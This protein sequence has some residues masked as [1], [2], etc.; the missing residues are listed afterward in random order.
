ME[1]NF[2]TW[3]TS[4]EL[5][6]K[7]IAEYSLEQLNA[8]PEGFSNNLIWNIGHVIIAQQALIYKACGL[9]GLIPDRLYPLYKPGSTPTGK[10]TQAEVEELSQLLESTINSTIEDFEKGLFQNFKPRMT[11]TGFYLADITDAFE[12]VNFHDGLHLGYM[13][14]LRKFV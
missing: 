13:M 8:I 9:D 7:F 14:S 4:R 11:G 12:F 10:T 2:K 3:K 6:K 5:I 1:S